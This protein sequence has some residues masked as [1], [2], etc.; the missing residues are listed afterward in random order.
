MNQSSEY[1]VES[2]IFDM[3]GVIIDSEGIWKRAEREVFSS[4]GVKLS[5]DLCKITET[6]TTAEVT[7]FWFDKQPWKNESLNEVESKVI[8]RVAHLIKEEGKGI[9]GVENFVKGLKSRGYKIGLATNSPAMLIP[10]VLEKL[11]L[12]E[13]FDATSSSEYELEGKPNPS[14]YLT[15]ARKLDSKPADCIAIEDSFSGVLAAKE[16]GMK[17]II[18]SEDNPENIDYEAADYVINNYDE[19]DISLLNK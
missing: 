16:A 3:D 13:Y 1:R 15:V 17:T 2:V 9:K 18:L 5:D 14:V 7:Q 8:K 4:V 10:V 11:N 12:D 19:F 6:M